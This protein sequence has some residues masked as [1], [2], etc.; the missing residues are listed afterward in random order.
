MNGDDMTGLFEVRQVSACHHMIGEKLSSRFI[1]CMGLVTGEVQAALIDTGMGTSRSLSDIVG[2]LT[3]KPVRCLITH[4]D[5]DHIGAAA[6]FDQVYISPAE[7]PRTQVPSVMDAQ[8]RLDFIRAQGYYTDDMMAYIGENL[9]REP[10]TRYHQVSDDDVFD[11]GGREL[12]AV[13]LPG[14][15]MGSMCYV[16]RRGRLAFTGDAITR[17]PL[18][19]FDRC[20]P[21]SVYLAALKRFRDI[22]DGPLDLYCG[23]SMD[24]LPQSTLDDLIRG[25][26]EI[27]AGGAAPDKERM[28]ALGQYGYEDVKVAVHQCGKTL[29]RYRKDH[30]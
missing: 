3:G 24:A 20:P 21:L 17:S 16:D 6:L 13:S 2:R 5:P 30:L 11:L 27:L 14:H 7:E 12:L 23:H 18:L 29:I 22:A 10:V 26:G 9:I 15:S 28:I 1:S 4:C 25:C 8:S 19:I